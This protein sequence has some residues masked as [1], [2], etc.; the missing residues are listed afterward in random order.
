MKLKNRY[1]LLRHGQTIYQVKKRKMIYPWPEINPI[2]LT[3]K[4]EKQIKK[5]AKILK[6]KKI[7]LIYSSDIYRT[8][9]TAR[10]VAKELG[11]PRRK[12]LGFL[13]GR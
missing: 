11:K 3:K 1:F 5:V 6:N 10:I 8:K 13:R 4:G 2:K 9:Q 7:D 12:A